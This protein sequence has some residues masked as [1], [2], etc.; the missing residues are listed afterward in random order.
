MKYGVAVDRLVSLAIGHADAVPFGDPAVV[1]DDVG[2]ADDAVVVHILVER[3]AKILRGE[4]GRDQGREREEGSGS[5][6]P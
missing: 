2:A 3:R 5:H 4:W 1:D 6:A